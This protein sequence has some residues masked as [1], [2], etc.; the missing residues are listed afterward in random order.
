MIE[1]KSEKTALHLAAEMGDADI[2]KILLEDPKID[3]NM[4]EYDNKKGEAKKMLEGGI[5]VFENYFN[6]QV[7]ERTALH[8]AVEERKEEAVKT[9]LQYPQIDINHKLVEKIV[10]FAKDVESNIIDETTSLLVSI[11]NNDLNIFKLLMSHP[12]INVK[13]NQT[14]K[15][16]LNKTDIITNKS[17]LHIA[18]E[19]NNIEIAKFL[20][21]NS[22]I[23]VNEKFYSQFTDVTALSI[24][25]EKNYIEIAELLL[26]KPEINVNL[27]LESDFSTKTLLFFAIE[28]ERHEIV[29]LML[30]NP[31]I[32]IN[33]KSI[34]K[35]KYDTDEN[36]III[37]NAE[38]T[39][40][41]LAVENNLMQIME[42]LLSNKDI[43]INIKLKYHKSINNKFVDIEETAF[44]IAVINNKIDIIKVLLDTQKVD[45]NARYIRQAKFSFGIFEE[46]KAAIHFA[47]KKDNIELVDILLKHTEIDANS[48]LIFSRSKTNDEKDETHLALENDIISS[49]LDNKRMKAII[50][51]F[52]NK[53]VS[54]NENVARKEEKVALSIALERRNHEIVEKLLSNPKIDINMKLK[55][56]KFT[57]K[58]NLLH[59]SEKTLIEIASIF[60][61]TDLMT[62]IMNPKADINARIISTYSRFNM[63]TKKKEQTLLHILI[64]KND[65]SLFDLLKTNPKIDVNSKSITTEYDL[66]IEVIY[67]NTGL[68]TAVMEN[69]IKIIKYLLKNPEIDVNSI[70]KFTYLRNGKIF[71]NS[72][73]TALHLAVQNNNLQA[74]KLLL[75]DKR[76]DVS[77]KNEMNKTAVELT[78]DPN[79]ISLFTE[80]NHKIEEP[81]DEEELFD[82]EENIDDILL[83]LGKPTD[84]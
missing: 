54:K 26:N 16:I 53:N 52:K 34:I 68:F 69:N 77:V 1:H 75:S 38:K 4:V 80:N 58:D 66:G 27:V 62:L 23:D 24:A 70:S 47:V 30:N 12:D 25:I 48:K 78:K 74:I 35:N 21:N 31:S 41:S 76:I 18:C 51:A 32:E 82:E 84:F 3:I 39:A 64:E 44:H 67:E 40:L 6:E 28:N 15:A 10:T 55:I 7:K 5:V 43:D 56:S 2:I 46:E 11:T 71:D 17:A 61:I 22:K 63:I 50:D 8:C 29:K 60:D 72:N 33:Q 37:E 20:L 36:E 42:Y 9:L 81:Q 65:Y 19:N 49:L 83:L 79:V 13:I 14:G 73:R 57:S 59:E 45:I